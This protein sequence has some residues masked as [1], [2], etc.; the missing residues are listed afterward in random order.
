M[1]K[2]DT[3]SGFQSDNPVLTIKISKRALMEML[4]ALILIVALLVLGRYEKDQSSH[5]LSQP[6]NVKPVAPAPQ[7]G[8]GEALNGESHNQSSECASCPGYQCNRDGSQTLAL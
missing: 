7:S 4:V 3:R 6:E 1:E 2:P 5:P 8:S